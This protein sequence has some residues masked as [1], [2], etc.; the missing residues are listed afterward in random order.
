MENKTLTKN[1]EDNLREAY[2]LA[3]QERGYFP[4]LSELLESRMSED[5][6]YSNP[7]DTL[8]PIIISPEGRGI[9]LQPDSKTT[10][11]LLEKI[12]SGEIKP[13]FKRM[14]DFSSELYDL[15]KEERENIEITPRNNSEEE[16]KSIWESLVGNREV[17]EKYAS[18][19]KEKTSRDFEFKI[20]IP[21]NQGIYFLRLSSSRP[22][23]ANSDLYCHDRSDEGDSALTINYCAACP[24]KARLPI[25]LKDMKGGEK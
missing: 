22:Y 8:Y 1:T 10:K 14:W 15:A 18:F 2:E 13:T 3:N 4:N 20:K 11:S 9:I 12:C 24:T 16:R 21:S 7:L 17:L 6:E 25:T 5:K 19:V 23:G